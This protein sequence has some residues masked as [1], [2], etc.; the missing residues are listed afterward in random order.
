MKTIIINDDKLKEEDIERVVIRV[1]ALLFNSSEKILLAYNN[2]TYQFLGG[3]VE[4]DEDMK[5]SLQREIKEESGISVNITDD[6]FLNIITYDNNYF[7]TGRKVKNII[8]YYR[9]FSDDIPNFSYTQYDVLEQKSD[10]DLFYI[11]F[12]DLAEFLNH[13][14]NNGM[15]DIKI[16]REMLYALKEYKEVYG[17]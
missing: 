11:P 3:H 14:I 2:N 15:I 7:N 17:G 1:K 12:S 8:Y 5:L 13:N 10:F 4:E 6:A 9:V 16:G